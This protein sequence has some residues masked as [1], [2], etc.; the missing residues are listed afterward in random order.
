MP[1]RKQRI[2]VTIDDWLYEEVVDYQTRHNISQSK[3]IIELVVKGLRRAESSAKAGHSYSGSKLYD[4]QSIINILKAFDAASP[5]IQQYV[6]SVLQ[7]P[8]PDSADAALA[9]SVDK[10]I[11]GLSEKSAEDSMG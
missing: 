5:D 6:L 8:E 1:T 3:A 11:P 2:N 9:E 7:V 10:K 4:I